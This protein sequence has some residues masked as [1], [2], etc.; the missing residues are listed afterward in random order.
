MTEA[1]A[2]VASSG[3]TI[4]SYFTLDMNKKTGEFEYTLRKDLDP[5]IVKEFGPLESRW[6]LKHQGVYRRRV[7]LLLKR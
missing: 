7:T 5:T 6:G 1:V 3:N 2:L 4:Q